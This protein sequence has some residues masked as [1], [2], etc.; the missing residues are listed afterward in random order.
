MADRDFS[1]I[2]ADY[3]RDVLDGRR[4]ACQQV[5]A[6]CRRQIADLERADFGYVY[7]PSRG[8]RVCRFIEL[9]PHIKGSWAGQMIR[10]EPWQI[11]VVMTVFSWVG[12]P[13]SD[14]P[15][16]RRF[17][18]VYVEV[19]RKNAKSTLTSGIGLYML[20]LDD[21]GGAECYS[22]ATT[23]DQAKI[24]WNDA[25]QMALRSPGFRNRFGV[26]VA[27]HAITVDQSAS[28]FVALS[29]E[30]G[31]LDGLNTHFVSLDELHAHKTR[32]LYDVMETS[33]GARTQSLLWLITTAGSNRAG[34]CYETRE[35]VSRILAGTIHDETVFGVIYTVDEGDDPFS[36]ETWAK[37]NP[38]YGVSVLPDDIARLAA[39][40][41]D[42]PSALNTFL[43]KRLDVWVNADTAWMA[44]GAWDKCKDAT[45]SLDQ[46]ANEPVWMG[47]DLANR[48]DLAS[49]G[50]VFS[51]EIE[52]KR[53]FYVFARNYLC[54]HAV[55]SSQN[56]QYS[57]WVRDGRI[58]EAGET[59]TDFGRIKDDLRAD[60]KR[61]EMRVVAFDPFQARQITAELVDEGLPAIVIGM[62]VKELSE[63][64]KDFAAAVADGRMHHDG[65]PVL[66]WAVSNVVCHVD[67]KENVYPRKAIPQNKIDPFVAVLLGFNRALL[68]PQPDTSS[69]LVGA[70]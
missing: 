62:T 51:R 65:C 52:G 57:G 4:L 11:W 69:W 36:P 1:Q 35:R 44:A 30:D 12:A 27:A 18:T 17:R 24:V 26:G 3:T 63:P 53:H 54:E 29:S 34:I 21:E 58:I 22:A 43:T 33:T 6:A 31:T 49:I 7:D 20:A 67:A 9:L 64:M 46:F 40:A 37:A 32:G 61:F 60:V 48:D 68:E 15:G 59:S 55:E 8:A 5:K 16:L 66:A 56:S 10:L 23:R 13:D 25:R 70:F 38:N 45:L 47:A 19:P 28:R 2:A 14:R 50:L 41:K 39:K 42:T